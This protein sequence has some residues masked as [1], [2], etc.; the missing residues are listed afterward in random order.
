[1]PPS[2]LE[3]HGYAIITDDD[4][5]AGP[6][7]ATPPA[8]RNEADWAYFQS[9][10][11]KADLTA[12][13]RLGHEANPNP[14]R[15]RLVLS[16]AARGLETRSDASWWSPSEIAWPAVASVLL[17][18]GGRVAVPGGQGVFDLFLEIGYAAFHLTRARGVLA[19][20][21]RAIFSC[22]D[23]GLRAEAVLAAAGLSEAETRVLDAKANV[24][25]TVW[26]K[27][28]PKKE[29]S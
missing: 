25:L 13:G 20:G 5:I 16:H 27:P 2:A 1:M 15:R 24:V 3:I 7:G 4:R 29:W 17:P 26:R 19:P 23:H 14:R 6:D 9:E 11:D 22:C 21:G 10:L 8:L 12:L 28:A 18:A